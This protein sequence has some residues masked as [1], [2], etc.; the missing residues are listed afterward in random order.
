M[1]TTL[2]YGDLKPEHVVFPDGPDGRPV[3]LDPGLLRA[4]PM[5]DVA[6]LMSRTVLVLVVH[7]PA[8]EV[9]R[10]IFDG[11]ALLAVARGGHLGPR[12]RRGWVRHLL[13]LW[14]MDTVN[15]VT[16]YLS[17]PAALPLPRLG[18][19][20]VDR[21]VPVARLVDAVSADL[22]APPARGTGERVLDRIAGVAA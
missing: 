13:T 18:L 15:I 3:L 4:S 5:V 9:T 17:A 10:Q 16:T 12:E 11:L 2:A 14:L 6:K 1:G 7:R 22:L 20:L 8:P 19:A 21:A